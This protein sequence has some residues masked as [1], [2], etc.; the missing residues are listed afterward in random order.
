MPTI[1]TNVDPATYSKLVEITKQEGLLSISALFLK[2][3][4]VPTDRAESD[5]ILR[6]ALIRAKAKGS[7]ETFRVRD[8]FL[9][10]RWKA[11]STG[12]RLR[13]GRA[14]HAKVAAGGESFEIGLGPK[15]PENHQ[16]YVK[17]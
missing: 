3:A 16:T 14:F 10:G 8:L 5:E 9:P 6:R 13:A 4:G 12:A 1:K 2:R 15:T 17:R 7:G 11:F